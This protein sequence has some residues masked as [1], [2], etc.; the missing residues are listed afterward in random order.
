MSTLPPIRRQ[1]RVAVDQQTA[2]DVFTAGIGRWWPVDQFSVFGAGSTVALQDG[3][4][5]EQAADGSRAEWGQVTDWQP[6][7]ALAV[8]WHPGAAPEQAS[9]VRVT[10]VPDPSGAGTLVTVEHSGWERFADPAAARAEYDHGWPEV[11]DRFR[12]AAEGAVGEPGDGEWTW[13]A[14]LHR[15]GPAA[16]QV[17]ELF[18]DARFAEHLAFLGRM[19]ELGYLVAAGPMT[20]VLGEGMTILRLP[21]ADQLEQAVE[22]ATRDDASVACGFFDV[23]IRPWQVVMAAAN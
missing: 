11:L 23:T 15:P 19:R 16:P 8:T 6:P 1:V 12:A 22:L 10:F 21:G 9:Q 5:V 2:F 14:L 3:R 4:L 13:V 7:T 17:G 18:D 20:D